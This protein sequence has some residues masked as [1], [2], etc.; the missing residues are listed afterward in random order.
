MSDTKLGQLVALDQKRDAIHIAI[1]PVVAAEILKPGEHVGIYADGTA[2]GLIEPIGIVDPFL[3]RPV[4]KGEK[5]WLCL[6]QQTVTG[7]R[8][9][10]SHPSFVEDAEVSVRPTASNRSRVWLFDYAKQ[11]DLTYERLM[12]GAKEWIECGEYVCDGGRFEGVSVPDEFWE[13]YKN[14]TGQE[15]F[16]SFFTCSC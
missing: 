12:D 6:Y 9:Q 3:N 5:F 16:G 15:G 11:I 8:H 1:A 13:H 10:W 7:M 2:S 4:Q 14:V